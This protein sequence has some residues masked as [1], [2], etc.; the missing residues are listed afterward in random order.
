VDPYRGVLGQ[1]LGL[2]GCLVVTWSIGV[3]IV[4]DIATI[5][6]VAL[7]VVGAIAALY[8]AVGLRGAEA[9]RHRSQWRR[10]GDLLA[11]VEFVVPVSAFLLLRAFVSLPQHAFVGRLEL[12]TAACMLAVMLAVVVASSMLDWFYVRPRRDGQ[13]WMPPCVSGGLQRWERV[14]KTWLR[15]R[16]FAEIA[17]GVFFML[18]GPVVTLQAFFFESTEH[19]L[20]MK[21]VG[22]VVWVFSQAFGASKQQLL[23]GYQAVR[24][25][26][27]FA[28]GES[29]EWRTPRRTPARPRLWWRL[30]VIGPRLRDRAEHVR[31]QT[32]LRSKGMEYV[33]DVALDDATVFRLGAPRTPAGYM[34]RYRAPMSVLQSDGAFDGRLA[35]RPCLSAGRCLVMHP[36]CARD[37]APIGEGATE[38][39]PSDEVIA[40]QPV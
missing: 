10:R 40:T 3:P 7:G 28:L 35:L 15:H 34:A 4:L 13:V 26:P 2:L 37:G 23:L 25:P 31:K 38:S 39:G 5:A 29:L 32:R 17:F 9:I 18:V 11:S 6:V 1:S 30:P 8:Y 14:T 36:H 21:F 33:F 27:R 12:G 20:A 22:P 16:T 24:R 19:Q